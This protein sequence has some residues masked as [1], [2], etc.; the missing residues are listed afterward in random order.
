MRISIDVVGRGANVTWARP[1]D[2]S[3]GTFDPSEYWMVA[4]DGRRP[5][6][7]AA[8]RS[9][10][11]SVVRRRSCTRSHDPTARCS[12]AP[13]HAVASLPSNAF[14]GLNQGWKPAA[15]VPTL[16]AATDV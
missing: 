4:R 13:S 15:G 8:T 9:A 1:V 7:G 11:E 3:T 6:R 14:P 16:E 5:V 10:S 2:R 12:P